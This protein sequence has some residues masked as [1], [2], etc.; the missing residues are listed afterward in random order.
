MHAKGVD[1]DVLQF[2][3]ECENAEGSGGNSVFEK[4]LTQNQSGIL[5]KC[6]VSGFVAQSTRR[7]NGW[8]F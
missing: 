1:V 4:A 8:F 2:V 7:G 3:N 5:H 6:L